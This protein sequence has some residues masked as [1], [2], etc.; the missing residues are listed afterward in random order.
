MPIENIKALIKIETES[1]ELAK[2][3][4][5]AID[6][7][8]LTVP[9]M[10]FNSVYTSNKLEYVINNLVSTETLLATLLDLLTVFQVT[11]NALNT[12]SPET[13]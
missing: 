7:D 3:I 8:N 2:I 4:H 13:R 9:P 12:F 11:E 1:N 5:T 10:T 6:P